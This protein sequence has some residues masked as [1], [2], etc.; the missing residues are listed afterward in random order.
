MV[1]NQLK[2]NILVPIFNEA[3]FILPFLNSLQSQSIFRDASYSCVISLID[4]NSNDGTLPIIK[5]WKSNADEATVNIINNER[6]FVSYGLN[7]ALK[8]SEDDNIIV[9]MDVHAAYPE[10]Y[11]HYLCSA[12]LQDT[13]VGNVG[14]TVDTIPN[15][16]SKVARAIA[17]VCGHRFGVGSSFRAVD[18]DEIKYVD[19]VPFGCWRREVFDEIGY[20]D[21]EMLRNQDDEFNW[22]MGKKGFRIAL[23]PGMSV[24]YYARKTL[25]THST[26]FYQYGLFKPLTIVKSSSMRSLRSLFPLML[27]ILVMTLVVLST[28]NIIFSLGFLILFTLYLMMSLIIRKESKVDLKSDPKFIITLV[29]I[30]VLSSTHFSY[31]VGFVKGVLNMFR[32]KKI[33]ILRHSR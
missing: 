24:K 26:M 22:R 10:E 15:G 12:L 13:T 11:L 17:A 23:L 29:L 31:G 1:S 33:R 2:V 18:V 27:V 4:G 20:F 5:E 30:V 25:F 21:E 6:Q 9:R 32:S 8:N 3:K 19:T 28:I 7:L 16:K 14:V